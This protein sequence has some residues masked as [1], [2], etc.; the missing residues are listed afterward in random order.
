M[1][2][3]AQVL[4]QVAAL[5]PLLPAL[6]KQQ[7]QVREVQL[8]QGI[9]ALYVSS[10]GSCQ[11]FPKDQDTIFL[12]SLELDQLW[13]RSLLVHE[14]FHALDDFQGP[15]P[16][17]GHLESECR[18]WVGQ[19]AYLDQELQSSSRQWPVLRDQLERLGHLERAALALALA[20]VPGAGSGL[21]DYLRE[22][23]PS[24][25]GIDSMLLNPKENLPGLLGLIYLSRPEAQ[26]PVDGIAGEFLPSRAG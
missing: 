25:S 15:G 2:T 23:L 3:P 7:L 26:V 8:P 21:P 1:S 11:L 20:L 12:S 22:T 24:D 17:V 13:E 16:S 4:G 18:A 5:H 14:G 10:Q 9:Q 19:A 6:K